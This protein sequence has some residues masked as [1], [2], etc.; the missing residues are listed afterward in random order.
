MVAE[1]KYLG[2]FA[3]TVNC[4]GLTTRMPC[5]R[6]AKVASICWGDWGP[7]GC[8]GLLWASYDTVVGSAL[9]HAVGCWGGSSA[10]R[11]RK[12]LN[13]VVRRASSV[14]WTPQ[15]RWVRGGR[16]PSR[17]QSWTSPLTPCN[18]TV[19]ALSSFLTLLHS[20]CEKERYCRSFI[21]TA[22][23]QAPPEQSLPTHFVFVIHFVFLFF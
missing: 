20:L 9:L 19:E 17:R 16:S 1:Y 10:D 18:Q 23:R 6:R 13:K 12:R 5:T 15:R 3:L 7:L 8:R 14:C 4:T 11:D 22:I 2:G 21:P